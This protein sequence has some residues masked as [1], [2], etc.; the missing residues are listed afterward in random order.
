MML[1]PPFLAIADA[2]TRVSRI[3]DARFRYS[4]LSAESELPD[5]SS[6]QCLIDTA[7]THA[8]REFSGHTPEPAL[9]HDH[10]K[11]V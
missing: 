9:L 4:S 1:V 7:H 5:Q 10:K 6:T 2:R 11:T 8:K 3:G